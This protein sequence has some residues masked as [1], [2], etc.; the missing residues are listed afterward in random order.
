MS[1]SGNW[2]P[3]A[4]KKSDGTWRRGSE[5]N[6][7]KPASSAAGAAAP[8][9]ASTTRS[10]LELVGK[11]VPPPSGKGRALPTWGGGE[12]D[13]DDLAGGEE[14]EQKPGPD[15]K[16]PRREETAPAVV[17]SQPTETSPAAAVAASESDAA[18]GA[19]GVD[20]IVA[21]APRLAQHIA[22]TKKFNKV[23]A[24]VYTL[25]EQGL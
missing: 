19:D 7:E 1:T 25:F 6:V 23:A 16:K 15:A 2:M 17:A 18:S 22:S 20:E 12:A 8:A 10:M 5:F 14:A 11:A 21:A 3:R 4:L 13:L 9:A 24:M